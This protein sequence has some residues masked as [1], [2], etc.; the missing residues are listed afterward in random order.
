VCRACYI[1]PL[2]FEAHIAGKLHLPR[3]PA[4]K[5]TALSADERALQRLLRRCERHAESRPS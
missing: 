3:P 4:R 2:V 5:P 1:H